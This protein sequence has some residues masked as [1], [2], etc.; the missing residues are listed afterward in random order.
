[1]R[2]TIQNFDRG[3]KLGAAAAGIVVVAGSA[4]WGG[5]MIALRSADTA[6]NSTAE[7]RPSDSSATSAPQPA[8][9]TTT[10][11]TAPPPPASHPA[12]P[13]STP[14]RRASATPQNSRVPLPSAAPSLTTPS[15]ADPPTPALSSPHQHKPDIVFVSPSRDSGIGQ[16]YYRIGLLGFPADTVVEISGHDVYGNVQVA[17]LV[18]TTAEGSSNPFTTGFAV[19]FAYGGTC[20]DARPAAVTARGK[21][22]SVTETAP[23]PLECDGG[24][25]PNGPWTRPTYPAPVPSPAPATSS[26]LSGS[27]G[28]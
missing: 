23:R 27:G 9:G 15:K 5:C 10:Q 18:M 7:A 4:G 26:S 20:N 1:V 11:P 3:L 14:A 2:R 25:T 17:P 8:S 13:A 16:W 19:N 21:G 28:A 12:D 6:S 24:A 22:F